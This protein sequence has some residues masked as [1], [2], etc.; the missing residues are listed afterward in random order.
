V[1]QPLG[2]TRTVAAKTEAQVD[3]FPEKIVS[4]PA[5][6]GKN[7]GPSSIFESKNKVV[8]LT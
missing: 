5:D 1:S 6:I 8:L 2:P 4:F 3:L 7:L